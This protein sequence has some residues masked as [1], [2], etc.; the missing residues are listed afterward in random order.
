MTEEERDLKRR[1]AQKRYYERSK[2]GYKP[3]RCSKCGA[4]LKIDSKHA[5]I[6]WGCWYKTDEGKEYLRDKQRLCRKRKKSDNL[7]TITRKN[8]IVDETISVGVV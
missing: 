8:T 1:E 6:C 5:P 2:R 7:L 3:S 4:R